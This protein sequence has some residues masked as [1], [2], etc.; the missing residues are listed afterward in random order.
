MRQS[1]VE[2][3][4]QAVEEFANT[5]EDAILHLMRLPAWLS[6]DRD[7]RIREGKRKVVVLGTGWAAH[8]IAK[9]IDVSKLDV[10]VISPRNYFVFTPMLAAAAV[11]TVEYR[12]ILE[13]IRSANPTVEYYQGA[14]LCCSPG[15]LC[16]RFLRNN[17]L[18]RVKCQH[19]SIRRTF[20]KLQHFWTQQ[21]PLYHQALLLVL[22]LADE[23]GTC[24]SIDMEKK[25]L[26]IKAFPPSLEEDFTLPYDVPLGLTA[27]VGL[28]GGTFFTS[29][30]L[31]FED[32]TPTNTFFASLSLCYAFETGS[33]GFVVF[34][35][36]G[37]SQWKAEKRSFADPKFAGRF[38]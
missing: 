4:G 37:P 26:Q 9:I 15:I 17:D 14:Y 36:G 10:Y 34:L 31:T 20:I 3:L 18:Y 19:S 23:S 1:L 21:I 29:N 7:P 2:D 24:E 6:P 32:L 33:P 16:A 38:W 5:A 11:G 13:H 27:C 12:S 28:L 30:A 35:P 22:L 25:E 8:A